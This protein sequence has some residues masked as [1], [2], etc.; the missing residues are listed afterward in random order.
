MRSSSHTENGIIQ[1][2]R[3]PSYRG[4]VIPRKA[5]APTS[6]LFGFY[7]NICY[8][9]LSKLCENSQN[10]GLLSLS[11]QL[12]ASSKPILYL[13]RSQLIAEPQTISIKLSLYL[14]MHPRRFYTACVRLHHLQQH[15]YSGYFAREAIPPY[16]SDGYVADL[17]LEGTWD[18][19]GAEI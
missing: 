13:S 7:S 16:N 15:V 8:L 10:T 2:L 3:Q 5:A 17:R 14:K 19:Y 4:E 11:Y 1:G 6:W 9:I 18:K 12:P